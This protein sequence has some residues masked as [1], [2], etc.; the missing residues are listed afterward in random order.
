MFGVVSAQVTNAVLS[1]D[2]LPAWANRKYLDNSGYGMSLNVTCNAPALAA[3]GSVIAY[4]Y[5][6]WVPQAAVTTPILQQY[7]GGYRKPIGADAVAQAKAA[8]ACHSYQLQGTTYTDDGALD[9]GA[10][11][12]GA[13]QFGFCER[14]HPTQRGA[15]DF[16]VCTVTFGKGYL[17]C[18]VRVLDE[19]RAS[20][21]S[22]LLSELPAVQKSCSG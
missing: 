21:Q 6:T 13:G 2:R 18:S 19:T 22:R 9:L 16:S 1:G 11:P 7:V 15:H 12:S 4:Q 14:A 17:A 20:A 10:V 8:R 3:E 5:Q